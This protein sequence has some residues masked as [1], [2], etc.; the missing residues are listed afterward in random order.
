MG[1]IDVN[2]GRCGEL[3]DEFD[4]LE[5]QR[6]PRRVVGGRRF[7]RRRG[8]SG[9]RPALEIREPGRAGRRVT[10]TG[11]VT[12]GRSHFGMRVADPAVSGEHLRLV[13][14][15]LGLSVVDLGSRN[16]TWV[17]GVRLTGRVTLAAGDRI[18]AGDTV[19]VVLD[20]PKADPDVGEPDSAGTASTRPAARERAD[21]DGWLFL[22]DR[23]LGIDATGRRN[24]FP[25]S[26]ELPTRLP[27]RLWRYVRLVSM[28]IYAAD[29]VAMFCRPAIGLFV[30]F[31]IVVPI[32]PGL[33]LLAPG[34]W[35]NSCPLAAV[36][37]I[38][39]ERKFT[40]DRPP[41]AWLY[42][43]GYPISVFLFFGIAGARLA[44]LDRS[45]IAAGTVLSL[46]LIAAFTGGVLYKG[47]SGWCSSICPLFALQRLYGQTPF[48][49]VP[50]SHCRPCVGCAKNCIDLQPR[51]AYQADLA[52]P[53]A[54]WTGPR[55]L[56]AAALPG[57]V[58]GFFMLS[59]HTE[60][61]VVHRYSLLLVFMVVAMALYFFVDAMTP[62][63]AA[64]MNVGY[65]TI[66]L[67]I[68]YWY[69]AVTLVHSIATV[70][71]VDV[72]WMRWQIRVT[73]LIAT[74]VWIARTRVVELQ[75]R[76]HT[77]DRR[78]PVL[79]PLPRRPA[80][81]PET[82]AVSVT[83]DPHGA[84]VTAEPGSSLLEIAEQAGQRIEAG[85]RM[86]VCGADPV[87][88]LA[89]AD[90][91]SA[92]GTDELNT[93]RRL[94]FGDDTRMACCA[95]IEC[96]TVRVSLAPRAGGGR[97]A[98]PIDFDRSIVNIVVLGSGIAGV[99][100]ADFS[101]RGHPDC[102]IHLV[103]QEPHGPYNRMGISRLVYGRSAMR[104]LSLLPE[105][106]Y[107]EH[108]ITTWLNTLATGI[109]VAAQR[110][111]LATG[112][113]LPYDRLILAT[114]ARA[115]V[116]PIDG[117]WLPGC[118]VIHE[119][120]D[121]LRIRSYVQQFG[122]AEAVV[123][124]GGPLGIEIACSLHRLGLRVTLLTRGAHLLSKHIDARCARLLTEHLLDTGIRVLSHAECLRVAG[125]PAV[126]GVRLADG[127]RLDCDL[128]L[129]ATGILP[130]ID[131]ARAAGIPVRRGVLVDDR[132]RTAAPQVYAAGDVTEHR[133][134]VSGLW[135]VAAEQ[136]EVAAVNALGGERAFLGGASAVLLKDAGLEL[137]SQGPVHPRAG[138]AAIVVHGPGSYRRLVAEQGRIAGVT[139]LGHHPGDIAA[140]Q[141]AIRTKM[142]I[143]GEDF[144]ALSAGDWSVLRQS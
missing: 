124:G 115:L 21:P 129:T 28:G 143:S 117:L 19:I 33:F 119:A 83:F 47:K 17:N 45:G 116:P 81:A 4:T 136:G 42:S 3:A 133:G 108:R 38:P 109:D 50:N 63:S 79:L 80:Q 93:L 31:G 76:L 103:G 61:G 37:Q 127:R 100:A 86:G 90:A 142:P 48:V 132:M 16:G 135:P 72:S 27:P 91:L 62:L 123:A 10:L 96:G 99:T 88:V 29:I 77:G 23:I 49:T 74:L 121:A 34:I 53:V 89:G 84:T 14:S 131:L 134:Q 25:T 106:W 2:Y 111:L 113:E 59:G 64:M 75:F 15:P 120:D 141:Y 51:G 68:F 101:R 6:M 35:R 118:F 144:R 41:P 57:F 122:C 9:G 43:R 55:R 130:N 60:L 22:A 56:F 114:G 11:A 39:R 36:N 67:N 52:E 137:F 78:E 5:A 105:G 8:I 92:P 12:I 87:A 102:D 69:A 82:P 1:E 85:C 73:V 20:A 66:A 107:D 71:G 95:R 54:W 24:L 112:Q 94:G 44:G 125:D 32:L 126:H 98:A 138:G 139:V 30:F 7:R 140:A 110:V 70:T 40:R 65:A 58:L 46:V 104:G 26:S 128:F 13:P 97:I 18:Q